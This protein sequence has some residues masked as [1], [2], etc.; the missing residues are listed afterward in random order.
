MNT[1][2]NRPLWELEREVEA[3]RSRLELAINDVSR[4]FTIDGLFSAV[5]RQLTED[6]TSPAQ[7]LIDKA[8]NNPLPLGL[9]GAGIGW[10]LLG[11]GGPDADTLRR[12]AT[13]GAE[14]LGEG[15]RSA[16][17]GVSHGAQS[18]AHSVSHGVHSAA[19]GVSQGAH[20]AAHGVSQGAHSAA[21]RLHSDGTSARGP[22][23]VRHDIHGRPV[24]VHGEFEDDREGMGGKARH[25]VEGARSALSDA[26]HAVSDEMHHLGRSAGEL[27]DE[28]REQLRYTRRQTADFAYRARDE[29][30]EAYRANPVALAL[31]VAAV[32][33]LIGVLLPNS[34]REDELF[35][36]E[37]RY[38][39]SKV[40][41]AAGH[42]MERVTEAAGE[43]VDEA[44]KKAEDIAHDMEK[45]VDEKA[46]EAGIKAED[47]NKDGKPSDNKSASTGTTGT[48]GATGSKPG[49][50]GGSSTGPKSG[51]SSGGGDNK[52]TE[53]KVPASV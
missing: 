19:H 14:R 43:A 30:F 1:E 51:G 5:K 50:V 47:K 17:Y 23:V 49:T 34:R 26:G 12:R 3:S 25:A 42:A 52:S 41:E 4:Q 8:R 31:G 20:S 39:R 33:S 6:G 16:A 18:A 44:G 2:S 13:H 37:A 22:A 53:K 21:N 35:G 45:K 24:P 38:V 9:I 27:A 28:A 48:T 7:S 40:T 10:L 32:G 36:D 15:A 29:V 46:D 11:N